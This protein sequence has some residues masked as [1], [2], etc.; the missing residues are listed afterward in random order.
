MYISAVIF[1]DKSVAFTRKLQD[2]ATWSQNHYVQGFT[3]LFLTC[4][5]KTLN[6]QISTVLNY[7]MPETDMFAGLFVTF[8][9]GSEEDLIRQIHESRKLDVNGIIL[10]DFAHLDNKY[11]QALSAR[12]FSSDGKTNIKKNDFGEIPINYNNTHTIKETAGR[13]DSGNNLG[14]IQNSKFIIPKYDPYWDNRR[15]A[16]PIMTITNKLK[17]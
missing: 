13:L 8:M 7:K 3:P 12:V 11:V 4:D 9:G 15:K 5:S 2:W 14:T 1:P 6:S 16:S 17:K 10:F